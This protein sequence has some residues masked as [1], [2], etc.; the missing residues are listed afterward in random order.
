MDEVYEGVADP[1]SSYERPVRAE[2]IRHTY[3]HLAGAILAFICVEAALL[4]VPAARELAQTMTTSNAG[5]MVVLGVFMAVSWIANRWANSDTSPGVQYLGLGLYVV[6]EA[7]IF[8]PLI[9]FANTF[10]DGIIMEAAVMTLLLTAGL[11]AT[12]FLSKKDFSF[13]G[14]IL[15]IGGLV[16]L[17]AIV[18]GAIFGFTLGIAFSAIMV[19]F[20]AG[21][22]IYTTSN[23]MNTYR[24]GQH[25]AASLALFA[26][27]ALLFWYILRI[28][29]ALR[30]D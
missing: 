5:W 18:A 21:S 6:A 26:S 12:V 13:L 29:I 19:L 4:Q 20:A 11:T 28:L 16:A 22:I 9:I 1:V 27:V 10:Y 23:V 25:V 7:V 15:T 3:A 8:L 14:P 30:R 24:P 2:F 17:G